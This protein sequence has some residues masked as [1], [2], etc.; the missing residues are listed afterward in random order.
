[1]KS[2]IGSTFLFPL[3]LMG[4]NGGSSE[5]RSS[6]VNANAGEPTSA[7]QPTVPN[8][9]APQPT[10]PQP[11][12]PTPAALK[13]LLEYSFVKGDGEE[14]DK[15]V[16]SFSDDEIREAMNAIPWSEGRFASIQVSL[17]GVNA[18]SVFRNSDDEQ[19]RGEIIAQLAKKMGDEWSFHN[20]PPLS[21]STLGLDLLL[22]FYRKDGKYESLVKW[23]QV[24]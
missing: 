15:Q 16:Q 6:G 4:C 1:M 20:S 21:D 17:D 10:A 7:S 23:T 2:W 14:I 13:S 12:A 9:T 22:S 11:T 19:S 5:D 3:A 8:A 18:M 24:E